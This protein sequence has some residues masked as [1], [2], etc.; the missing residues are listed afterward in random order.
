ME[1]IIYQD[2]SELDELM[3]LRGSVLRN[4]L[5]KIGLYV[6]QPIMLSIIDNNPGLTQKKLAIIAG[7]KPSTVNVMLGRM[8]KNGLVEIKKDENN[9]KLS[10][11]YLTESGK[12]LA[13]KSSIVKKELDEKSFKNLTDEEIEIFKNL[14]LKVNLNLQKE[15]EKEEKK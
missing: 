1:H 10:R 7:I 12:E 5:T 3:Y 14:L 11:V 4:E 2:K 13:K 9:L 6:G 15:L 8:S